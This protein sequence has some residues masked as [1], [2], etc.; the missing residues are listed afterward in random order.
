M[1]LSQPCS[2]AVSDQPSGL[3]GWVHQY[4]YQSGAFVKALAAPRC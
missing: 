3:G 1:A 2:C 4:L